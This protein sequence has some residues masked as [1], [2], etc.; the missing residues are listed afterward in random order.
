MSKTTKKRKLD[1]TAKDTIDTK[2]IK[3]TAVD[4][5]TSSASTPATV[6]TTIPLLTF[7]QFKQKHLEQ[8]Q[9]TPAQQQQYAVGGIQKSKLW[10]ELKEKRLTSSQ[11]GA[12]AYHDSYS[13]PKA[14]LKTKLWPSSGGL[15]APALDWGNCYENVAK[16]SLE[17]FL[18]IYLANNGKAGGNSNAVVT[19]ANGAASASSAAA[20]ASAGA[21]I[22]ASLNTG[23]VANQVKELIRN[24]ENNF[25]DAQTGK[26][27]P[28]ANERLIP[29][30]GADY[31]VTSL[32]VVVSL[33]DPWL[34]FSPDGVV[35]EPDGSLS[36]LEIKCPYSQVVA[37][38]GAPHSHY[39]Q[40]QMSGFIGGFKNYYYLQYHPRYSLLRRFKIDHDY[41]ENVLLPKLKTFYMDQYLP[42]LYF[43][44]NGRL[45]PGET[46]PSLCI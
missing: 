21:A 44:V 10:F 46:T 45:Q 15:K 6:L 34:G 30:S 39:D 40:M 13:N 32:Q 35:R 14:L 24:F 26:T 36:G 19:V 20:V 2:K 37:G 4:T 5:L 25:F 23:S 43:K 33:A 12:A 16:Y 1:T 17:K 18:K 11:F 7:E 29:Y 42:S 8:L 27:K 31:K 3:T 22:N 41:C 9:V 28:N 38:R